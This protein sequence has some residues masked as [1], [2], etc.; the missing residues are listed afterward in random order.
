MKTHTYYILIIATLIL[1]LSSCKD[2]SHFLKDSNYREKVHQQF[3]YRKDFAKN[4]KE[5]LFGVFEE[6]SLNMQQREALEFLY[7]Y[8]PLT[9]LADY[10]GHFFLSQVDAAFKAREYF[11]WGKTI[12]DDVFRHFVLVYRV[13]NEYLDSARIVF[14]EELKERIKDMSMA[15]AALEV[16]HWCHEKVTYRG[17]DGRTS[18]PLA[19]TKTSWGRCGE[20]SVLAV[21]ALRAVGIPARQCYTPRWV[22]TDSNH[23]WVEVWIDGKWH[24]LGACEPEPELNVAWFTA[25]AKRAMMIHTNVFGLYEGPEQPNLQTPFYSTINLLSNYASTRHVEVKVIDSKNNPVSD[26]LVKYKVYNYSE[27]Y[28]IAT[29]KTN[30]DGIASIISGQGDLLIW[31]SKNNKYGY[32]K[33]TLNDECVTLSLNQ[34]A[35]KSYNENMEMNPPKE[36]EVSPLSEEKIKNNAIRLAYEDSIRNAYMNSFAGE[37]EAA[38]L[39]QETSLDK[40]HLLNFLTL[41]QGN[42]KEIATFI[43]HTKDNKYLI[44]YLQSLSEKDLRDTPAHFL[45]DHFDNGMHMGIKEGTPEHLIVP[46]ILS[47]RIELELITPWRKKAHRIIGIDRAKMAQKDVMK[48]INYVKDSITINDT[49]NYYN[50]RITPIGTYELKI[51]DRRSRDVFFVA[52]CRSC[53]IPARIEQSTSTP[54]YYEN[55]KWIDV[56]FE[57][58]P[59]TTPQ[60]KGTIVFT[61]AKENAIMPSYGSHYTLARYQEEDFH[62]LNYRGDHTL[63]NYPAELTLDEG[64]YRYIVGSRAND[65]SVTATISY[66]NLKAETKHPIEIIL[67]EPKG[68]MQVMGIVDMNSIVTLADG[69]KKSLKDLSNNKGIVLCFADPGKE[70]T[71]HILQ[72]LPAQANEFN[73]WGGGLLFLVPDDKK[74]SAFDASVFKGL[75]NQ[76]LWITDNE[77]SL[78]N[79]A[80]NALN[81]QLG[82]DFPLTIYLNN[83]GGILYF[84]K[85]YRIGIGENLIRTLRAE[86]QTK[87]R[88]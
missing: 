50:C 25:P 12:P 43:R 80:C 69:T 14:F 27:F 29:V 30:Q 35:G 83:N 24:Y 16:N 88:E 76:S 4:R 53:G 52:L 26:A 46:Y 19:L 49:D 57:Q 81:I 60:T 28:P 3:L 64:Y 56:L 22:H 5:A 77:R 21:T 17:T 61:N 59:K 58:S 62:T 39:A 63:L 78:L 85:G 86:E 84:A 42:W 79:Q 67:P 8:M 51:A 73:D 18:A 9:D 71:K 54:Q 45:I 23:A 13:N 7:A 72:D 70:P 32:I 48:V 1:I 36:V 6:K 47:P 37:K 75:P 68:K 41:A 82:D 55:E 38:Y 87:T 31:A 66:F 74:S 11:N 65:G 33:S 34:K 2:N 20:E 15:E 44:P 40:E 10:D